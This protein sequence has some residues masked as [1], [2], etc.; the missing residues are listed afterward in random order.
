MAEFTAGDTIAWNMGDGHVMAGE[1]K[2]VGFSTYIIR[3]VD[4]GQCEVDQGKCR[5]ASPQDVLD[6]CDF[7]TKIGN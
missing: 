3:R 4:G 5:D 6:A 1:V 2:F 7:F